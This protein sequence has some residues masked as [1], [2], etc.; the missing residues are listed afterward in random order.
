M[1]CWKVGKLHF[2]AT[3]RQ[4]REIELGFQPLGPVSICLEGKSVDLDIA[5]YL[6]QML[7]DN[8]QPAAWN[9]DT[10]TRDR[11]KILLLKGAQGMYNA[12]HIIF[13]AYVTHITGALGSDG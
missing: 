12:I 11:V 7:Q 4:E 9:K 8:E 5:T 6:D 13:R 2:L 10:H 1:T 3:S